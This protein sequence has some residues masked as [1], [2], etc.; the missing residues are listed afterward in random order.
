MGQ[1]E[2]RQ[3]G[4]AREAGQLGQF[5]EENR[6]GWATASAATIGKY[7]L[8]PE[9]G[10]GGV[11]VVRVAYDTVLDRLVAIKEL[12]VALNDGGVLRRRF[13]QE[14]RAIARLQHPNVVRVY[15]YG[16]RESGALYSVM[17]LLEGEDL[18]SRLRRHLRLPWAVA[19][20]MIEQL[21]NALAAAHNLGIV[22]RDLKPENV[23]LCGE[24]VRDD[25]KLLDFGAATLNA[26]SASCNQRLTGL[27]QLLGTP[28]YMS[29][30]QAD[31]QDTDYR[32]DLWSL[33]ILAYEVLTGLSPFARGG[34]ISTLM[35]ISNEEAPAPSSVCRALTSDFNPFFE[36]ALR[37]NPAD[38]FQ[39]AQDFK[40][41]FAALLSPPME[42]RCSTV[43]V[44]DDE[45]DLQLLVEGFF[46][47]EI[48]AGEY[49]FEFATNGQDALNKVASL[50]SVSAVVTDLNMPEMDGL[51]LLAR[52]Q[53]E[54]PGLPAIVLS[55]YSDM[56]NI[57]TAMN[58]NAY[59]FLCKPIDFDDLKA[60]ISKVTQLTHRLE[61][62]NA[63]AEENNV[64]RCF[65]DP[66][67]AHSVRGWGPQL[68]DSPVYQSSGSILHIG[69]VNLHDFQPPAK[70]RDTAAPS[71]R[72]HRE[73]NPY[74][75]R[76]NRLLDVI[77]G[78]TLENSG[79]VFQ[80]SDRGLTAVF[81]KQN[82][83]ERACTAAFAIQQALRKISSS[84]EY[85]FALSMGLS[86][87]DLGIAVIGAPSAKR[88]GF[89][90][91]GDALDRARK[92]EQVAGQRRLLIDIS[93]ASNLPADAVQ[94]LD[95]NAGTVDY[96]PI[97]RIAQ[98]EQSQGDLRSTRVSPVKARREN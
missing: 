67:L 51:T 77:V 27:D 26:N 82:H 28:Q 20:P 85:G 34:P 41:A 50:P 83:T 10:R 18:R 75:V 7:V 22:H 46:S 52:L 17:E 54:R 72:T 1:F 15:D 16:V 71:S 36:K 86:S 76:I 21:A 25:V 19:V 91:L 95:V 84:A 6:P 35:A 93:T 97:S 53:A 43:L 74:L 45:P 33:A 23:F 5:L 9:L 12:T 98:S 89:S 24:G 57:R 2:Q 29:P 58:L 13:T 90:M 68:E 64:L 48:D 62:G 88:F 4:A 37:K 39:S 3:G 60:T 96:L 44:V 61:T 30:E 31:S 80:M 92:L 69:I 65:M 81:T 42:A 14:A 47:T 59:D 32:T 63:L 38:R 94:T 78:H 11:G 49:I 66:Q 73:A 79:I 70:A 55:A 40:L 56:Q 87:G 8:G